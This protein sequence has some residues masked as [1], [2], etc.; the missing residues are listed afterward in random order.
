M[1]IPSTIYVSADT[2]VISSTFVVA[3][4]PVS[5]AVASG[6]VVWSAPV[7]DIAPASP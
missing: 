3:L 2:V 7:R 5:V 4:A 1:A 6:C